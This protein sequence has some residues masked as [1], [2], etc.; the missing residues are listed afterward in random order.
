MT[1]LPPT[2]SSKL[3]Q[4]MERLAGLCLKSQLLLSTVAFYSTHIT[5]KT[6]QEFKLRGSQIFLHLFRL[7][8]LQILKFCVKTCANIEL[9]RCKNKQNKEKKLWC[10]SWSTWQLYWW[11]TCFLSPLGLQQ[12]C[13]YSGCFPV[14]ASSSANF[15]YPDQLFEIPG[16]DNNHRPKVLSCAREELVQE[17]SGHS[18]SLKTLNAVLHTQ[19]WTIF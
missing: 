13:L 18:T 16:V 7:C 15:P 1:L 2:A 4:L 11:T 6:V 17:M 10:N 8:Y 9:C 19:Y 14:T 5:S 3:V 12:Y